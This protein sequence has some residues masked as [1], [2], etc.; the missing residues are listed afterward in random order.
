MSVLLSAGLSLVGIAVRVSGERQRDWP[1]TR[2]TS[3]VGDP[4]DTHHLCLCAPD[5]QA[6]SSLNHHSFVA[7]MQGG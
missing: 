3:S 6:M 7:S 5:Q 4:T 1:F 2:L